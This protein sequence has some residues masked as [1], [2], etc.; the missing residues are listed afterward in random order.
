MNKRPSFDEFKKRVLQDEEAKAAYDLLEPEFTFASTILL[1]PGKKH[2]A[3]LEK[4]I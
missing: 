2:I 3:R 4:T 1:K